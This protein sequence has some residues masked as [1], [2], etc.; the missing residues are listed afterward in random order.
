MKDTLLEI[1]ATN[2]I[3]REWDRLQE[4]DAYELSRPRLPVAG[5]NNWDEVTEGDYGQFYDFEC[6]DKRIFY[7]VSEAA[8]QWC[9]R[10]LPEDCPRYRDRGFVVEDDLPQVVQGAEFAGLVDKATADANNDAL[11]WQHQDHSHE[12]QDN[13]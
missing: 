11:W 1:A 4:L 3:S 9:Y 5:P 10:N 8:L 13:G 6:I 12:E 2:W 7:A